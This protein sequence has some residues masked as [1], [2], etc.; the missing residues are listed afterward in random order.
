MEPSVGSSREGLLGGGG[1]PAGFRLLW[2]LH[3]GDIFPS[4]QPV[5]GQLPLQGLR[6]GL[7]GTHPHAQAAACPSSLVALRFGG[8]QG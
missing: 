8:V 2:D 1:E 6:S 4:P 7:P 3:L 5:W